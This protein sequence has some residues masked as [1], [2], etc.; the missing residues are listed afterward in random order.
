MLRYL[1][2]RD[3]TIAPTREAEMEIWT[4]RRHGEGR[5]ERKL[6]TYATTNVA[7]AYL[8]P[9]VSNRPHRL[10]LPFCLK[11]FHDSEWFLRMTMARKKGETSDMVSTAQMVFPGQCPKIVLQKGSRKPKAIRTTATLSAK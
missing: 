2:L 8:M 11:I 6:M 10:P 4:G 9:M 5:G 1:I 7:K 3:A